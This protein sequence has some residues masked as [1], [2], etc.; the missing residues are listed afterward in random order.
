MSNPTGNALND[1]EKG[2]L[3]VQG[4]FCVQEDSDAGLMGFEVGL[5][6]HASRLRELVKQWRANYSNE[7]CDCD[8]CLGR[9]LAAN[10]CADE[11]EAILDQGNVTTS[12]RP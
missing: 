3:E 1:V 12:P 8:T 11:L 7:S 5:R 6:V 2:R 4:L 9:K 10:D